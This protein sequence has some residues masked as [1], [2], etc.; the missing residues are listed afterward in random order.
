MYFQMESFIGITS[1]TSKEKKVNIYVLT[2]WC[3]TRNLKIATIPQ[4]LIV[5]LVKN[6]VSNVV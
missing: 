6:Y 5:E 2:V 4:K 3:M 1:V